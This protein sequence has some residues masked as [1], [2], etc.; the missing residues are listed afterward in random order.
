M[1]FKIIYIKSTP[2]ACL[3]RIKCRNRESETTIDANYLHKINS[4]YEE[5]IKNVSNSDLIVIDGN[6]EKQKVFDQIDQILFY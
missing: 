2:E 3:K 1:P 4:K 5:W 6:L